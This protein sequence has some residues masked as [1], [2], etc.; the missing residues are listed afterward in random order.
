[1]QKKLAQGPPQTDY[2]MDGTKS[3]NDGRLSLQR[4]YSQQKMTDIPA[5]A[6]NI[7]GSYASASQ[8]RLDI[9]KGYKSLKKTIND[10]AASQYRY[11]SVAQV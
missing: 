3:K 10:Q 5:I 6:K 11:Q 2:I 7:K 1:M 4:N 9:G 8:T